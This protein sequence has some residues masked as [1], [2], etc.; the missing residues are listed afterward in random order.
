MNAESD[1][2]TQQIRVSGVRELNIFTK[3]FT[4]REQLD[5]VLN[6]L[7]EEQLQQGV[8]IT[9]VADNVSFRR[10]SWTDHEFHTS[11]GTILDR[12]KYVSQSI[13]VGNMRELRLFKKG[14]TP[15]EQITKFLNS[16]P[17]EQLQ[18]G[19]P[20]AQVTEKVR[21]RQESWTDHE[22]HTSIGLL[23]DRKKYVNQRIVIGEIVKRFIFAKG[24]TPREQITKFLNRLPEEQLK[25]GV[26]I[27]QVADNVSFRQEGWTDQYFHQSIGRLLDKEKHVSQQINK[28]T[29]I[30]AIHYL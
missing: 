24:F 20:I 11:I 28:V 8:P 26:P 14:F 13:S 30:F 7:P 4:P 2:L 10:E 29:R 19:V 9:Q 3:G 21:F 25:Q 22:F 16:L 17:E 27:T 12:K 15:R 23:L 5:K 1:L 18:Q 6:S